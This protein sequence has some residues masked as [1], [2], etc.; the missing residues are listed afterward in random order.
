MRKFFYTFNAHKFFCHVAKIKHANIFSA[1][2]NVCKNSPTYGM[3][4]VQVRI[5]FGMQ[6][7][8]VRTILRI[9]GQT[10]HVKKKGAGNLPVSYT[11]PSSGQPSCSCRT[12]IDRHSTETVKR[13]TA[14]C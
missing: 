12:S 7:V 2:T 8:Q 1:K 14:K 4:F 3:Q 13:S 10:F 6:F 11:Q 5:I 9:R